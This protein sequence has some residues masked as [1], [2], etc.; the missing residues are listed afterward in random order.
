MKVHATTDKKG[1]ATLTNESTGKTVT[2]S[3]TSTSALCLENAELIVEDFEEGSSL[4]PFAG[5]ISLFYVLEIE[6]FVWG[7]GSY[8]ADIPLDF[9]TVTFTDVTATTKEGTANAASG[10]STIDI[11]SSS[12]K[13]LTSVDIV[14][15][16][17]ITVK[18]K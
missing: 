11:E 18:Y 15:D 16:T 3:L 12:D 2:K 13:V 7:V 1:V 10:A 17:K 5:K 9:G 14:S 4:V 8:L 6:C